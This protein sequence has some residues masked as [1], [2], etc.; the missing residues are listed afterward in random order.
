MA[1][2]L[3]YMMFYSHQDV[4]KD[5]G[6]SEASDMIDGI[7]VLTNHA[8]TLQLLSVAGTVCLDT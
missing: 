4:F 6:W 1:Q 7:W 3:Q 2:P 8:I 5:T